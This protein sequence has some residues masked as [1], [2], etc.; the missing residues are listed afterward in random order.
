MSLHYLISCLLL[1]FLVGAQHDPKNHLDYCVALEATQDDLIEEEF[2]FGIP[3]WQNFTASA[4]LTTIFP[5][6][7]NGIYEYRFNFCNSVDMIS[8]QSGLGWNFG[9]LRKFVQ[10]D[11][12]VPNPPDNYTSV[13]EF[14]QIY[15]DG[16]VGPPCA[17]PRSTL[18][19][20]Y[21]GKKLANCT[22]IP[23]NNGSSCIAGNSTNPGFCICGILF[24]SSMCTG[25]DINILS[26]N[27]SKGYANELH[28]AISLLLIEGTI[29]GEIIGTIIGVLLFAYCLGYVYN[30]NVLNRKG[31]RALPLYGCCNT[32]KQEQRNYTL[33][34]ST[35]G[36][37]DEH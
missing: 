34:T 13:K 24:N 28:P 7:L 35:Y 2:D 22:G 31:L 26:N 9:V 23:G 37:I 11:F 8:T 36:T 27:C 4:N 29:A 33:P 18:V 12:L 16:D 25:L 14:I 10:L 20:I 6:Y 5:P 15:E 32:Q 17:G 21:C 19:N 30:R 3:F 1:C